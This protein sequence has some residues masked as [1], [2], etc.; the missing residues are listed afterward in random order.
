MR[1][2]FTEEQELL[3][4]KVRNFAQETVAAAVADM[5]EKDAFPRML[6]KAMGQQGLMGLSIPKEWGG[7]GADVTS[8]IIAI[9][10]IS[11]VSAAAGVILSVH[12]SV[13]SLPIVHH[14][15]REQKSRF[16]P[17]LATGEGLGAFALT[18]SHAGSDASSIRTSAIRSGDDY[19]LNGSK[20]FITNAGEASLY[21][22]FAVV[23]SEGSIDGITA[24]IVEKDTPGLRVGRKEKKMGLHGSNTCELIFEDMRVPAAQ[25]LGQEGQ[26]FMIAKSA[27]TG[28]RIGIG[29][30]A[31]GIARAAL[32]E[33][34]RWDNE[35]MAGTRSHSRSSDNSLIE[36]AAQVEAAHLLVYRAAYLYQNGLPC[37]KEASMAKMFASD[38][39]MTVTT[40]VLQRFGLHGLQEG[41]PVERYFRDAKVT[42]IYE[43]TNEI[44]RI[45]ISN[46]LLKR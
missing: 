15:T 21:L 32:A 38:T 40:K 20:M 25:R 14:G 3:R 43:G 1:L 13:A 7:A 29:A 27:L 31:L 33:A 34:E 35:Q 12:L 4:Q 6:L 45:V 39:A 22:V 28:G 46:E 37:K 5:E 17:K 26:G 44:H 36:L 18:E 24:F 2:H 19:I 8:Y 10:E 42:Q 11:R 23:K 9:E 16:L 41:H 30:Q